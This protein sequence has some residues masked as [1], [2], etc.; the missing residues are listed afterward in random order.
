M[1]R[2]APGDE[3]LER[4]GPISELRVRTDRVVVPSPC[5]DHDLCLLQR[6]EDLAIEQFVAELAVEALAVAVLPRAAGL[7]IGR[8]RSDGGDPVAQRLGNELRAVVGAYAGRH[9]PQDEQIAQRVDDTEHPEGLAVRMGP[10]R[11]EIVGPD[12]VGPF[13]PQ[14]DTRAV[15]EPEPASLGLLRWNLQPLARPSPPH[16]RDVSRRARFSAPTG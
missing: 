8:P 12:M 4:R 9:T 2:P 16:C 13:R 6:V 14:T 7:D 15:I 1:R 10:V 11:D 3:G 5:F